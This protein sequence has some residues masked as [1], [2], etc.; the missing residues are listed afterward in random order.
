MHFPCGGVV[1]VYVA[2]ARHEFSVNKV[3]QLHHSFTLTR[4]RIKP[5]DNAC[6]KLRAARA[7]AVLHQHED[8][9]LK[10]LC[11]RWHD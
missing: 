5:S 1:A 10:Y 9:L 7:P 6:A 4:M 2:T 3:L 8:G 11:L